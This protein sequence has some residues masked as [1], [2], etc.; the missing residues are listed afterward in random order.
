[1][2]DIAYQNKDITSKIM[3]E[4]LKDKSFAVYGIDVPKV[5]QVLPTNLPAIEANELRLDNLFLLEDGSLALVDYESDYDSGDKVKYLD[6][7]SRTVK[8]YMKKWRI[9]NESALKIRMIVIYTADIEPRQTQPVL[10][11]GC[12]RLQ[13]EEAF[14][15]E[16]DWEETERELTKKIK[17]QE[18]LTAE[19]QM[20]F[21]VLPLTHKGK[22]EKQECIRRCFNLA[23][24]VADVKVQTFILSGMLVF[25]DKVITKEDSKQIKEWI[26]L[27]KVGQLFEEEK[28]EYAEKVAK[29][30]AEKQRENTARKLLGRGF[31]QEEILEIVDGLTEG[32]IRKLKESL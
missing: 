28:L 24:K 17:E 13:V 10:D 6:Y 27:T 9:R 2:T 11:V 12:L 31:S 16:M 3:G 20:R 8:R 18:P 26:M 4:N 30:A 14:L 21:I 15:C 22:Q 32:E 19:D 1:M 25:S 23:R 5:R 7:I 29:E